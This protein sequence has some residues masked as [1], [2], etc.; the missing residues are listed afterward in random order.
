MAAYVR[1]LDPAGLTATLATLALADVTAIEHMAATAR[2][3]LAAKVA[4]GGAW[5]RE[6]ARSPAEHIAKATGTSVGA[7]LDSLKLAE[8]LESLPAVDAAARS[9]ELSPQQTSAVVSAA[10]VAPSEAARLVGDAKR[11][12]LRELQAECGR[13]RAAHVDREALRRMHRRERYLRSWT[14]TEGAGHIHAKGTAE[15]VAAMMARINAE[16]DRVFR[17]AR[18]EGREEPA[19][20][21][22][23]DALAAICA[24]EAT[25]GPAQAKV[26]VRVDLDTL[27][28]GYP[29]DGETC[30]VAGVPVAASAV[31]DALTCGSAFVAAVLTKA[32]RLVGFVH[33][34]RR[35]T[36][37]QQT[38]LEWI[39]PTCA[40]E[41][42]GQS[43]RLQRDHRVDWAASKV[44]MFEL[45]DLLCSF[46]HG[47]KTTKN[48][49]LVDGRGTRPFVP[50]DD[51]RH[52]CH[53]QHAPPRAA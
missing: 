12:P 13:T 20:A 35:P 31:E 45:L 46:H 37:G 51:P 36:V 3:L 5:K 32:E 30:E 44:T 7:V 14:D 6:G 16:R 50:P 1:G 21:Y 39:Y 18:E 11:L 38:G 27:L 49:G 41:G 42:C 25:S 28:R 34:G 19:E 15:D 22:S 4:E 40:V 23:F 26:I 2:A 8:K 47:L 10:S 48:W 29:V 43:A 52:P 53:P 24:G 33:L 9:G 17:R